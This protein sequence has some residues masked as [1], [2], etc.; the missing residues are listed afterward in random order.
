MYHYLRKIALLLWLPCFLGA[1]ATDDVRLSFHYQETSL[2]NAIV[3][4]EQRFDLNFTYSPSRLPMDYR[5]NA[6]AQQLPVAA[7]MDQLFATSPIKHA[8]IGDQIVLRADPGRLSQIQTRAIQPQQKSPLYQ[9]RQPR[10]TPPAVPAIPSQ[11]PRQ[12]SGGDQ[13]QSNKLEEEDLERITRSMDQHERQ[14]AREEYNATHRLAQ[15]SLLPYLGTNTHRSNEVTNNVSINVF[16]GTS[17]A[18]DGFELGGV[19]NSVTEDMRGFQFAGAV[20][21][22][23]GKVIGTQFAGLLNHTGGT[24]DGIQIG[25]IGNIVLDSIHGAQVGGLFNVA[26]HHVDGN[27]TAG[28]FNWSEG[29]V[30]HQVSSIYNRARYVEKRQVGLINICDTTA[31]APYGLLNFV[32][33]GYNR[34]EVGATENMYVNMSAKFGV[35]KLYNIV[36]LGL[37]WDV[38]ET[39]VDDLAS[40]AVYTSWAVGYGLGVA[41]RLGK[42]V[43]LNLETVAMHIN[44]TE[45]WTNELNLLGQFRMTFDYQTSGRLSVY[46]GPTLNMMWSQLYDADTNTYGSRIPLDPLWNEQRGDTNFQGWIGFSAGLRF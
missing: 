9:D 44:E 23:G 33:Y 6:S 30:R 32:K 37:R 38:E 16:W 28:L 25:G 24:V 46:A 20:N 36:Q 40:E 45:V 27:Q 31:K 17:K 29:D 2:S 4:L 43:L 11:E 39:T 41:P 13:W 7:A 35:R 22:V 42:K 18:V 12:I 5:L 8:F 34:L 19:A 21:Q 15:I 10:D 26:K 3:D 1:Q 14:L